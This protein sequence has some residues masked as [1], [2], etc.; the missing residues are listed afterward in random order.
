[1][2]TCHLTKLET[3]VDHLRKSYP[4]LKPADIDLLAS[5]LTLAGRHALAVY[6]GVDYEWPQDN[7]K[8]T[9]AIAPNLGLVQEQIELSTPKRAAKTTTEE[10]PEMFT[11]SV[12]ANYKA[13]EKIL[14]GRNELKTLLSDILAEKHEFQYAPSDIGWQWA[15]DR[16]GWQTVLGE[17][18]ELNRRIKMKVHFLA[19]SEGTELGVPGAKKRPSRATKAT[20][21]SPAEAEPV[22]AES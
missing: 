4:K 14:E 17:G 18:R 21:D 15:L 19:P 9:K 8:L 3:A 13:G 2:T 20:A 6:D 1:L 22:A 5:A 10:E 7:E 16:V 12:K 11:I